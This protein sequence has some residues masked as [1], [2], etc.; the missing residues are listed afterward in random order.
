MNGYKKKK[1]KG[2]VALLE[3][4]FCTVGNEIKKNTKELLGVIHIFVHSIHIHMYQES[5]IRDIYIF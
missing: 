4:Y 5:F 2:S 1:M 3:K